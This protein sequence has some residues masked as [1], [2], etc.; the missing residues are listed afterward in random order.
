M[1]W[2]SKVLSF[3]EWTIV[4]GHFE[5]LMID[6][7][8]PANLAMF[9]KRQRGSTDAEIFITGPGI[10]TI[11]ATSPGGWSNSQAPTGP[12]LQLLIASGDAWTYFGI[13]K[14]F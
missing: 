3:D 12:D 13:A 11:E 9:S 6:L 4:Q 2:R 14:P 1:V 10:D 7:G 8:G 5:K